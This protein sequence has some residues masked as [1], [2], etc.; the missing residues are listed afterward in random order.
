MQTETLHCDGCGHRY[1]T[2]EEHRVL[3][4][5]D[6]S[7]HGWT[8]DGAPGR[9]QFLCPACQCQRRGHL[10]RPSPPSLRTRLRALRGAPVTWQCPR[11]DRTHGPA[12]NPPV[13]PSQQEAPR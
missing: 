11:C 8:L 13:P 7:R 6:A 4:V 3:A 12:T 1:D 9:M 10:W 2:T 5:A